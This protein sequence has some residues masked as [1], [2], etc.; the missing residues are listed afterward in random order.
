MHAFCL[1]N[2]NLCMFLYR[3]TDSVVNNFCMFL[4]R[5]TESVVSFLSNYCFCRFRVVPLLTAEQ[6]VYSSSNYWSPLFSVSLTQPKQ[7]QNFPL[8]P[9]AQVALR[10]F[11]CN[12]FLH[13]ATHWERVHGLSWIPNAHSTC[14]GARTMN[15]STTVA[16]TRTHRF[17]ALTSIDGLS[18]FVFSNPNLYAL[19]KLNKVCTFI[20]KEIA[21]P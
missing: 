10:Y 21:G 15:Q 12:A 19:K 9:F 8:E 6:R 14:S 1:R 17:P 4:N 3:C 16:N 18:F 11:S 5:C 13:S 20:Y 7:M 2:W